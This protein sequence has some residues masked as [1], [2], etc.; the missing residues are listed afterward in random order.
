MQIGIA[1]LTGNRGKQAGTDCCTA[2]SDTGSMITAVVIPSYWQSGLCFSLSVTSCRAQPSRWL[3]SSQLSHH[4]ITSTGAHAA[5]LNTS[6]AVPAVLPPPVVG[7]CN[8]L[9]FL[10]Q[11]VPFDA[12]WRKQYYTIWSH[13]ICRIMHLSAWRGFTAASIFLYSFLMPAWS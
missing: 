11:F 4:S 13:S 12:F 7:Q 3:Q 9:T 1:M 10:T 6:E 5:S 8:Y 2:A